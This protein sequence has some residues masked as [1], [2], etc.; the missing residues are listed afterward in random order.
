[1]SDEAINSHWN[2]AIRVTGRRGTR[3]IVVG[4]DVDRGEGNSI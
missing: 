3:V 1:M 4:N 2:S